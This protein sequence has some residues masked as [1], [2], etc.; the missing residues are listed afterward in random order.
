[1]PSP[2]AGPT[3]SGSDVRTEIEQAFETNDVVLFMKGTQLMPQCGYS[4]T[5]VNI[6]KSYCDEFAVVNVL[7][8][9][10]DVYRDELEERSDWTTIPQLFVDGSF[11]GGADV[12]EELHKK[13]RLKEKLDSEPTEAPF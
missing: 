6:V 4:R 1:M 8:G 13:D 2:S 5:A 10:V 11:I 7:S 9:P 12:I 3:K